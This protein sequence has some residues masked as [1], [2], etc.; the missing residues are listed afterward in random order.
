MANINDVVR[1][2]G[3]SRSTVYRYFSGKSVKAST[4]EA[5]I[6]AVKELNFSVNKL[7][8]KRDYVIQIRMRGVRAS[9]PNWKY[10]NIFSGLPAGLDAM[11]DTIEDYG[12]TA[13]VVRNGNFSDDGKIDGVIIM[14]K[15]FEDELRDIEK[16]RKQGIPYVM[17]YRQFDDS[18]VSFITCDNR[19]V[20]YDVT[21]HF[22]D[23]G[24]KRI[25]IFGDMSSSRNSRQKFEGYI[26]CL[27]DNGLEVNEDL[28]CPESVYEA[29]QQWL[30]EK[31]KMNDKPTAVI[32]LNDVYAISIA[33]AIKECGLRIPE[34][35]AVFGMDNSDATEIYEPSIS[36]VSIPFAEIGK[37]AVDTLIDLIENPG[38][39][40][41][42]KYVD[43]EL[44][45]RKSSGKV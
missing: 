25:A 28:I 21:Q 33:D 43:Y 26:K 41:I 17:Y 10:R 2:S 39:K 4:K 13:Q 5:I 34:D 29:A 7:K 15:T 42:K 40:S 31:L 37:T 3:A 8:T 19:Q 44:I 1:V 27:K 32:G 11:I 9:S 6:Q 20:C 36:S 22:I 16:L 23:R 45:F 35:V 24:H 38:V 18:D 12:S 14:G 30:I